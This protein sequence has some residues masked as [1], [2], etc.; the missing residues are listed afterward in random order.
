MAFRLKI[1]SLGQRKWFT[2]FKIKGC[3][4]LV[5]KKAGSFQQ[6]SRVQGRRFDK[7]SWMIWQKFGALIEIEKT[8]KISSKRLCKTSNSRK[9]S[10]IYTS[11]KIW[12]NFMI[13]NIQNSY[14]IVIWRHMLLKN[15]FQDLLRT[16]EDLKKTSGSHL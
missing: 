14:Q 13:P 2:W 11:H 16:W 15:I 12:S 10:P 9:K 4:K 8:L 3:W 6:E 5:S 7:I 1:V